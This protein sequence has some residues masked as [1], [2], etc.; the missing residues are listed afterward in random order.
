MPIR[1]GNVRRRSGPVQKTGGA[2]VERLTATR[3]KPPVDKKAKRSVVGTASYRS[4]LERACGDLLRELGIDHSFEPEFIRFVVPEVH[5]RYLPDFKIEQ[6]YIETKG[7]FTA[8]DRK[9]MVAV[10]DSNPE[11]NIVM[12][13]S[14]PNNTITKSSKTTYGDWCSKNNIP[15]IGYK[16]FE[17]LLR[18]DKNAYQLFDRKKGLV[19]RQGYS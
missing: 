19:L 2:K 9:K 17:A 14:H 10:L 13:F 15:W 3:R 5:R 7:R 6:L 8:E 11:L 1:K 4:G 12:V 16:D 18:K